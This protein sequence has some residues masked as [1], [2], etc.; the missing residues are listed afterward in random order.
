MSFLQ[1]RALPPFR[2]SFLRAHQKPLLLA[3]GLTLAAAAPLA[4]YA[5]TCYQEWLTLGRGGPPYNAIGWLAQALLHPFARRDTRDPLPAPYRSVA[6]VAALYGPAAARS[7]LA[8]WARGRRRP[9]ARPSVPSFVAPQRQTTERAPAHVVT[10][11]KAFLVALA[12]ANPALF[13]IRD[14]NLEGPLH[15]ALY[16]RSFG[17]GNGNGDGDGDGDGGKDGN[18]NGNGGEKRRGELR[19]RLGRGSRGEFAHVHGEGS[20]HVT[21]SAADA[22]AL[23]GGGWAE[24][25]RLSGVGGRR[26]VVPFGYVLL[27]APRGRDE[28]EF[29]FEFEFWRE[30]VLAGA[31]Y[32]AEGAGVEVVVPE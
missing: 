13:E 17:A 18:G 14:S 1:K 21:V 16:L 9:G 29:E 24:R 19:T 11:Q 26:A 15:Q 5:W 8:A 7:Y 27:Y 23:V 28:D 12:R 22:A 3:A 25:H 30:A 10:R 20:T 32:A 2:P 6:D 31:R 4:A